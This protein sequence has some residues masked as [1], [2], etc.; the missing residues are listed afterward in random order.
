M[1]QSSSSAQSGGMEWEAAVGDTNF[2]SDGGCA[3]SGAG[4]LTNKRHNNT[5]KQGGVY[6]RV[7]SNWI[8]V[9]TWP[10]HVCVAVFRY[11]ISLF[12]PVHPL[13]LF[14][15]TAHVFRSTRLGPSRNTVWLRGRRHDGGSSHKLS[16]VFFFQTDDFLYFLILK[17]VK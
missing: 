8:D 15:H 11:K 5:Q 3:R 14:P 4:N 12:A 17:E 9:H 16:Q 1:R 13:Q 6:S 10:E 2:T 7:H